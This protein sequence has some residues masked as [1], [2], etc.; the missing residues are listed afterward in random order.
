MSCDVLEM[1]MCHVVLTGLQFSPS[2]VHSTHSRC[3]DRKCAPTP[4]T[5]CLLVT[6]RDARTTWQTFPYT[7]SLKIFRVATAF[8]CDMNEVKPGGAFVW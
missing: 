5:R 4:S 3:L 7:V 2:S 8:L 1:R 6:A